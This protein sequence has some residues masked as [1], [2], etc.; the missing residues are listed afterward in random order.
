M[1]HT[2]KIA[3][4]FLAALLVSTGA[5]ADGGGH[6]KLTTTVQKEQVTLADD[7]KEERELVDASTV[8]P[9]ESVVYTI[10]F[11]NVSG[12][13]AENV[14]ITNPVPSNLTYEPGSAFGPGAD[15]QFSVDG[16]TQYDAPDA[17]TVTEDGEVRTAQPEDYTHIRWV[18]NEN[19]A[20]GA[21]GEARFRARLN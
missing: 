20:A 17:L 11:E 6:L 4:T 16:G 9:G 12:E 7:G 5:V 14:T 1:K 3:F 2:A 15:I 19:L 10:T 8:V 18:M 21:Q 13:A